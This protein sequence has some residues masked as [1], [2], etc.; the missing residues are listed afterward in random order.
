M[1]LFN[2]YL[3]A[4]RQKYAAQEEAR[5]KQL[6]PQ[7]LKC[8][9]SGCQ[10]FTADAAAGTT[11]SLRCDVMLLDHQDK[12]RLGDLKWQKAHDDA[13]APPRAR[14]RHASRVGGGGSGRGGTAG[15]KGSHSKRSGRLGA[16]S[17]S[18]SDD[19]DVDEDDEDGQNDSDDGDGDDTHSGG[20]GA[21]AKAGLSS[22]RSGARGQEVKFANKQLAERQRKLARLGGGRPAEVGGSLWRHSDGS[23]DAGDTCSS[24][25]SSSSNSITD[26]APATPPTRFD[27]TG[28]QTLPRELLVRTLQFFDVEDLVDMAPTCRA[29]RDAAVAVLVRRCS[30]CR[31]GGAESGCG[32]VRRASG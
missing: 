12:R 5:R 14:R 18:D 28:V 11:C 23:T 22:G 4:V 17:I 27:L 3:Q 2:P 29:V 31:N 9:R 7:G 13:E 26:T 20:R 25:S 16:V 8:T 24:S 6:N 19:D 32:V 15:S 10:F 1:A 21:R 30:W